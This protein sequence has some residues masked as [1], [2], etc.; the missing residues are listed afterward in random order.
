MTTPIATIGAQRVVRR[1]ETRRVEGYTCPDKV[2]IHVL[3]TYT[4]R[5]GSLF[6]RWVDTDFEEVPS[7]VSISVGCFG[8]TG[9]WRSRFSNLDG[10]AFPSHD[11]LTAQ[12]RLD[13]RSD[14]GFVLT[15]SLFV[16]ACAALV[17]RIFGIW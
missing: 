1:T 2:D 9:G 4:G 3:Q 15:T 6:P 12:R 7:H 14:M 16:M 13:A 10:V 17:H 5:F 11:D 8:D